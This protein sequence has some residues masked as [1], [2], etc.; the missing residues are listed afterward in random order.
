M[1]QSEETTLSGMQKKPGLKHADQTISSNVI[2]QG[3]ITGGILLLYLFFR[4]R[5]KWLYSPNTRNRPKHPCFGYDGLLSW[6]VPVITV[7]DSVLLSLIGLD[8]FMMLQT[9][10]LL[11]RFLL[12]LS[13]VVIPLLCCIFWLNPAKNSLY[14][15]QLLI[16][17]SLQNLDSASSLYFVTIFVVY[18]ASI[19]LMYLVYIYYKRYVVLRQAYLRNPT[20][21][22]SVTTLKHLSNILG[23]SEAAASYI[24]MPCKTL[25][26]SRIPE[27]IHTDEDLTEFMNT[28][29]IGE[30][31]ECVLIH[32]TSML[33][34]MYV[35]KGHT[36]QH[37]EKE[38]SNVISRMDSWSLGNEEKCKGSIEGFSGGLRRTV[39]GTGAPEYFDDVQKMQLFSA[40]MN[41]AQNFKKQQRS[42]VNSLNYYLDKLRTI[43]E[44]I[45]KEKERIKASGVREESMRV[46]ELVDVNQSLF[47]TADIEN[48]ASFFSIEHLFSWSKYGKYFTL[49][50]PTRSKKAFVT[51]REQKSAS[52]VK[53]SQIGSRVFS[54][55]ADDAPAPNDIIWA[56]LTKNEVENYIYRVIGVSIFVGFNISFYFLVVFV[57]RM[58]DIDEASSKN[59]LARWIR[60]HEVV[61]SLYRGTVTPLVF[62]A[63]LMFVPTVIATLVDTEGIYSYSLFQR[64]LMS[65]LNNFLFFNG[66][67]SWF[68]TSTFVTFATNILE[69]KKKPLVALRELSD[70]TMASSVFFI[71]TIFQKCL[72]GIALILLKPAPLLVNYILAPCLGPKTRRQQ[73]EAE[74]SPPFDFGSAFPNALLIFSMAIT[75]TIICPPILLLGAVFYLC[76]YATF[77]VEFL[78]SSRNEYESG[79][80]YWETACQ[81]IVFSLLF[82]QFVSFARVI[83]DGFF[84]S[85]LFFLPLML[86]TWIY[87]NG[88]KTMFYKSCHSYPLN[89]KEERYLD[90]FTERMMKD[91]IELLD[92][93][94]ETSS[95]ADED[96]LPLSSLGIQDANELG[97]ASY[98]RD[99]STTVS[100][101]LLMLP[102]DFY[103]I[104]WF[105]SNHDKDGLFGLNKS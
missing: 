99:P 2:F 5:A 66:F 59:F 50:L 18:F 88:L 42:D 101:Q 78:Y 9:F 48:D 105:L 17:L 102:K 61:E 36:M 96:L 91:R 38:I 3:M 86:V 46:V 44:E 92:H 90:E 37:I 49:D 79:G 53:Q 93:W 62:N 27:Y 76:I 95:R 77:K 60:R 81:N 69:G 97:K 87:R 11:Y 6:V 71:N 1:P 52:V 85:S 54:V 28:L 58:L 24:N 29:D 40:F 47:L 26:V 14:R 39:E 80:N 64:S 22:T 16:K 31:E 34:E 45:A 51:F 70:E 20:I 94:T 56:N 75:Y 25:V 65:K 104:V 7:N 63:L 4:G 33:Q 98:Y 35:S 13:I 21:M 82:L 100:D 12:I 19:L 67:V 30:I 15:D 23:S 10:K 83:S 74:Y 57:I 72:V 41:G 73:E 89:I 32:D 84:K 68:F 55:T 43:N 8:A 103:K